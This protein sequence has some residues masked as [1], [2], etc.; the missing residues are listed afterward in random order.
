MTVEPG[1][2]YGRGVKKKSSRIRIR[3]TQPTKRDALRH[4]RIPS[5]SGINLVTAT[6]KPGPC[7]SCTLV[8]TFSLWWIG[9]EAA[10]SLSAVDRDGNSKRQSSHCLRRLSH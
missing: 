10:E 5:S 6:L 2:R 8:L 9:A 1:S 3:I 4:K 7:V